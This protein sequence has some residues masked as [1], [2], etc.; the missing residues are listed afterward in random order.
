[1]PLH[2]IRDD[3]TR[4][5][6]DAI[7]N[8]TDL[9]LSGSGGVDRRIQDAAGPGL[10]AE[11]SFRRPELKAPGDVILTGAYDLPARYILHTSGPIWQG[12]GA[13]EEETLRACYLNALKMAESA[14][15]ETV[16]FPIISAGTFGV[17][18][19]TA[20]QAAVSGIAAFLED[21]EI[22]VYLVVYSGDVFRVS[23]SLYGPVADHLARMERRFDDTLMSLPRP[24]E[25]ASD[26][27]Q[28]DFVER[29]A[30]PPR[31]ARKDMPVNASPPRKAEKAAR[32]R[33]DISFTGS[34]K[35]APPPILR[36]ILPRRPEPDGA[37]PPPTLEELLRN[38]DDGFSQTL[39]KII[40]NKGLT[41][42]QCY[43]RANI[44]R[45][46]FSKIRSNPD[47]KPSKLT[48]LAFAVALEMSV[49]E[50]NLLLAR[51]GY[52]LSGASKTDIIVSYFLR[53]KEYDI[54]LINEV[55]FSYDL[56]TLG[57]L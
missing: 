16:A 1:M 39:L 48:A 8:A 43:K 45:K 56:P 33:G 54:F 42:A 3:I 31:S 21:H 19:E 53:E 34:K 32:P 44:D 35:S 4:M 27:Y 23:R 18:P 9:M 7:V 40:D 17:P 20:L 55:L 47:Y 49:D 15:C 14:A 2:I 30:R 37:A 22:T 57:Q 41:D 6:V 51:A 12:G 26:L 50:A 38:R 25:A 5:K 52:V 11:L 24:T 46:L 28:E 29:A 13:G 36:G 10:N